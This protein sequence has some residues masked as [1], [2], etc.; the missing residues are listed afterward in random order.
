MTLKGIVHNGTIILDNGAQ[1]PD[2]TRVQVI[3]PDEPAQPPTLLNSLKLA[4]AVKGLPPDLAARHD[5]YI[6]GT[7]KR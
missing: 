4:G 7:P 1:I 3:V 6:H 5:H 2:G